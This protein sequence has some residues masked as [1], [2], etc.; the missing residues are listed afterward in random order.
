MFFL[1][2]LLPRHGEIA[3]YQE[4]LQEKLIPLCSYDHE[5]GLLLVGG[6]KNSPICK[7]TGHAKATINQYF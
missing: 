7:I 5:I 4:T 1:S 3:S 2:T 6:G